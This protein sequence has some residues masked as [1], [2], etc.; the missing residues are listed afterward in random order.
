MKVTLIL[1]I[2]FISLM[3]FGMS[4][5]GWDWDKFNACLWAVNAVIWSAKSEQS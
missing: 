2:L 5:T 4:Q 3:V 1:A